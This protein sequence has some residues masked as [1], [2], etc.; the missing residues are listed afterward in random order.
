MDKIKRLQEYIDA[1][2]AAATHV[3]LGAQC[4]CFEDLDWIEDCLIELLERH[5]DHCKPVLD[6]AAHSKSK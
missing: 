5:R 6:A 1:T 2:T 3:E 4:T